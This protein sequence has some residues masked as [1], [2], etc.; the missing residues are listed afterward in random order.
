MWEKMNP[1]DEMNL[2]TWSMRCLLI[3]DGSKN[4]LI[5]C[6]IGDK[7]DEKFRS[8]FHPHGAFNLIDSLSEHSIQPEDITDV[9]LTHLHFDHCGGALKRDGDKIVPTFP[10]ATYWSNQKHWDWA[11]KPNF[12]EKASFLSEN[13]LP[14]QEL[15]ILKMIDV[16]QDIAWGNNFHIRFLYG[17][18]EAMMC[19]I[20]KSQNQTFIYCA[21]LIPSI[22]HIGMPYVMSY[23]VR[24]LETMKEKEWLLNYAF[25]NNAKLIL[26]HD[27]EF[28]Y[29]TIIKNEKNQYIAGE[30]GKL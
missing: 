8:H 2:C 21:D 15:G 13:I 14:L 19:P 30:K 22:H 28:E 11:I 25:E 26:E 10:N 23:D 12:R 5:D 4:I 27:P 18:T 6:G 29:C 20:I 24:P 1:P 3:K 16:Q 9:F 7:Q 17:H